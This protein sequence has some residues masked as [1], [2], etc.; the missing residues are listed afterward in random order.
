MM[1][2]LCVLLTL[3]CLLSM[4]AHALSVIT[5]DYDSDK[6]SHNGKYWTSDVDSNVWEPGVYGWT[7][8]TE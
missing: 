8:Y 1:R 4:P 7:E 5:T 3:A 2:R 6:V